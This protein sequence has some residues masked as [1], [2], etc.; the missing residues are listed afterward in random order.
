MRRKLYDNGILAS[1][2]LNTLEMGRYL[3][4]DQ[5]LVRLGELTADRH[6]DV[7]EKIAEFS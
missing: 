7:I 3:A 5:F 1:T 2:F 6:D 4:N